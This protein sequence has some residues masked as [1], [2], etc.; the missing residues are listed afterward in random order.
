MK[1]VSVN[2]L[3]LRNAQAFA[4]LKFPKTPPLLLCD[5]FKLSV[6]DQV[7]KHEQS[8]FEFLW[9]LGLWLYLCGRDCVSLVAFFP[10]TCERM[11]V[12]PCRNGD[13]RALFVHVTVSFFGALSLS[14][15]LS[16]SLY[17]SSCLLTVS[18][19]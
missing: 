6:R 15:S 14:L 3:S 8:K 1:Q 10:W 16:L 13:A 4:T 12:W 11:A 7:C 9:E 18:L 19:F 17:P 2:S 5:F